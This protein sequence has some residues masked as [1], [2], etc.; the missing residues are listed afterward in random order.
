[1]PTRR[2]RENENDSSGLSPM[3]WLAWN[4]VTRSQRGG[5]G[6]GGAGAGAGTVG[7]AAGIVGRAGLGLV[8]EG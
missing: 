5:S 8:A 3:N 7:A 4:S 6:V 2:G 1:M